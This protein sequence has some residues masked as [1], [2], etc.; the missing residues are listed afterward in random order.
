ME[1]F[2]ARR[3]GVDS[4]G[5]DL[6][7]LTLPPSMGLPDA[8]PVLRDQLILPYLSGRTFTHAVW[9]KGGWEAVRGAWD[10]PPT[11]TEQILHP[12]KFMAGEAARATTAPALSLPGGFKVL[13]E[14][15]LGELLTRTLLGEGSDVAAAGWGGD[16]FKAWDVAGSTVLAW[17][18]VWDSDGDRRE[19]LAA[20]LAAFG[21][22]DAAPVKRGGFTMFAQGRWRYALGE[23]AGSVLLISS[24][25]VA[26]MD[27]A[28]AG[29]SAG[30]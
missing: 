23:D 17:R 20:A 9:K 12:E 13:A 28:L 25:N 8:P 16:Q 22:R 1:R 26:R 18:T 14:G 11:T 3:L 29:L 10:R 4:S 30:R 27:E 24:D 21:A 19:F 7:A 5:L 15:V 6:G 2:L